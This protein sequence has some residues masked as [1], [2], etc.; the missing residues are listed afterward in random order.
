MK[1][2][3][4]IFAGTNSGC[5][6]TTV[7]SG[8]MAALKKRGTVVQ[9]YKIG[10]DYIDP[11]F[12][13]FIT[14]RK[15]ANLDTWMLAEDTVRYLL[16][17]NMT[18]AQIAVIEGVMGMYDGFGGY[19]TDG[20]TA[21]TAKITDTPLI[22]I[23]NG[24]GMSL[25]AS[26]IVKGFCDFDK[27][28]NTAGVIINNIKNKGHFELLK[29][30]IEEQTGIAVLG[31]LPKNE[32]HALRSRHL[33]LV[34]SGELEGLNELVDSLA[35]EVSE[36]IDLEKLMNIAKTAPNLTF[37]E[38][39][40]TPVTD[41]P[42][43]IAVAMDKAFNFYYTD[44]IDLLSMLGAEICFFSPLFDKKLPEGIS[45]LYI[46]GGY[47]EVYAG[48]L[49]ENVEIREDIRNKIVNGLPAYA[50]CG[51]F[52]YLTE[53]IKNSGEEFYEMVGVYSGLSEMTGK[54]QRFGYVDIEVE[55]ENVMAQKGFKIRAHEFHY[56]K[57]E[58][59]DGIKSC[60]KVKKSRRGEISSSWNC[61]YKMYNTLAG[62]PHLHFWSNIEFAK[63]F[64]ENFIR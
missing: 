32:K 61:G 52:M 26:A 6:K 53:G 60:F 44:N 56:S 47:P 16:C 14:G 34:P 13:T 33:G 18:D 41:K 63:R 29:S 8:V 28:V 48:E 42:V 36:T 39:I 62:Y 3:R 10:P 27:G 23:L 4:I 17:K 35:D 59:K 45:G 2:P 55:N 5:G 7:T 25:S 49:N 1:I 37:K 11:M 40:S 50:E 43:K 30:V 46:G 54:L 24:E 12:H 20:S 15:S 19:S 57:T 21:H 22:L 58:L 51:G 9:P 64:L 38:F 31:Y